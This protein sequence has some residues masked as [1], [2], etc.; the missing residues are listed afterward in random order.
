MPALE[1]LARKI[2]G[3][4]ELRLSVRRGESPYASE[5]L[6]FAWPCKFKE[7]TLLEAFARSVFADDDFLS[8][9]EDALSGD[10]GALERVAEELVEA[11]RNE[12]ENKKGNGRDT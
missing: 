6:V 8:R 11:Y 2:I 12:K 7:T 10:G 9:C 1:L 4:R 5:R 3:A